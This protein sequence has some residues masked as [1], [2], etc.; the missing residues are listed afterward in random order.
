MWEA[1]EKRTS[2]RGEGENREE[3]TTMEN[4]GLCEEY[5][6]TA[7]LSIYRDGENGIT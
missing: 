6:E 5:D 3:R 1:K 7:A 4:F 2:S